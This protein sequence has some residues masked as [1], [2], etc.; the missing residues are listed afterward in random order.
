MKALTET[1]DGVLVDIE[2]SPKSKKFEIVGYN[3]WREKIEI[4]LK[5]PPLKGKA[6]KEIVNEFEKITKSHVEIVSGFKSQHKTLK[7]YN[8]SKTKILDIL[9]PILKNDK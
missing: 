4:R 8:M 3:E 2:V 1:E 7:I 6:N 9:N 5:S